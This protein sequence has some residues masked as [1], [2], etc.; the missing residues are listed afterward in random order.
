MTAMV[1][2]G[3]LLLN[4]R[5]LP[6]LLLLA[7]TGAACS[8]RSGPPHLQ[9]SGEPMRF[10]T[11]A[12]GA[13]STPRAGRAPA[14]ETPEVS[15]PAPSSP[16]LLPE[17]RDGDR[18]QVRRAVGDRLRRVARVINQLDPESLAADQKD[19]YVSLLDYVSRAHTA[20]EQEDLVGAQILAEKASRLAGSLAPGR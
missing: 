4:A 12:P 5:G 17:V 13:T 15:R 8:A 9:R 18:E 6:L 19:M 20:L 2:G 14:S 7:V 11:P 1:P 16:V 3:S 10:S